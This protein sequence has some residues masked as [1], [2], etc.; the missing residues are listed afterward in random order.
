MV[1]KTNIL[2]LLLYH[3]Y[4]NFNDDELFNIK[5]QYNLKHII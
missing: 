4:T 1:S 5:Q 3:V 2:S